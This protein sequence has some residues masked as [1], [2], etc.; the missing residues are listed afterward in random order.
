MSRGTDVHDQQQDER[1]TPRHHGFTFCVVGDWVAPGT[2]VGY[3]GD[4]GNAAGTP[5]HLHYGVY[6]PLWQ[7]VNPYPLL[8]KGGRSAG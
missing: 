5:T 8:K 7:A 6:T 1:D 2:V 4:S 3:V